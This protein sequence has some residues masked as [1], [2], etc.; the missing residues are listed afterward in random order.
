LHQA[1]AFGTRRVVF[2]SRLEAW[3]EHYFGKPGDP[4]RWQLASLTLYVGA[5]GA[6][7][8]SVLARHC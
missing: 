5:G 7:V 8:V 6:I 2:L 1:S 3:L 4:R